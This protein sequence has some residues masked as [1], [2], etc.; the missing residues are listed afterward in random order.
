VGLA[1]AFLAVPAL[2]GAPERLIAGCGK[3]IVIAGSFELLSV[4]GF[5]LLFKLVF[6]PRMSWRRSAP[7]SLRAL[8][9]SALLPGGG[10]LGPGAGVWSAGIEKPSLSWLARTTITFVVLTEAPGVIVLGALGLLLWLGLPSGPHAATLTLL[11][12][13]LA[14]GVFIAAWLV[15]PS[16]R[17]SGR[18]RG[19]RH[20]RGRK[21]GSALSP[22]LRASVETLR[23]GVAEAHT[24]LVAGNWKLVGA[25]AYYAF[26]NAVLW[27][28]FHAYGRTPALD[29]V[30]MGYLVG[31]LGSALPLPGGL[32]VTGGM[33]GALVVYGAPA[34][35]AA[36][37]VLLYR[38][39]ALALPVL[40]G[41]VAWTFNPA[42]RWPRRSTGAVRFVA[43]ALANRGA[44]A[45]PAE[46][47]LYT[48][49]TPNA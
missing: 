44:A 49:H 35:P 18:R 21:A 48:P 13:A 17:R 38:G 46:A 11:P 3:W 24:L 20:R 45:Q 7:A 8:G 19:P 2:T 15:R 39:I 34:A 6:G 22:R 29:V 40:L 31:S 32:G 30:V 26:D 9:A 41:A 12:A 25:L 1:A 10:V 33:V 5:V 27:S 28:A 47:K 16:S 43:L 36:A 42:V 4:L 23:E 37:A 14:L